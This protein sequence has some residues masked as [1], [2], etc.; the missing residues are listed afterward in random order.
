MGTNSAALVATMRYHREN[1][2]KICQKDAKDIQNIKIN[3]K[4]TISVVGNNVDEN[5]NF[6]YGSLI[7]NFEIATNQF[8]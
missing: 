1:E 5:F 3:I 4:P 8:G 7:R 6:K 2:R